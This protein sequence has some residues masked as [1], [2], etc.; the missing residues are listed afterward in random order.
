MSSTWRAG[1]VLAF[2]PS[3]EYDPDM[4]KPA[5][6]IRYCRE[7]NRETRHW[8]SDSEP[9]FPYPRDWR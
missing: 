1:D 9:L 7:C 8:R 2:A 3:T 5:T 4:H 6:M